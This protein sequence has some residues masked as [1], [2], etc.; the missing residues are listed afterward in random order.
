MGWILVDVL[1]IIG[2]VF[3][4]LEEQKEKGDVK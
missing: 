3:G 2:L 4:I 1:V